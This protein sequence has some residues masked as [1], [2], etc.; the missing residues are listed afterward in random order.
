MFADDVRQVR[1]NSVEPPVLR[2]KYDVRNFQVQRIALF[3]KE[4]EFLLSVRR[5]QQRTGP[6]AAKSAKRSNL[7]VVIDLASW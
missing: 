1:R 3:G 5:L 6:V 7:P 2:R 4:R